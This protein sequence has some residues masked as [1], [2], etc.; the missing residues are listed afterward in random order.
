MTP[1]S[2]QIHEIRVCGRQYQQG[3][4]RLQQAIVT[5]LIIGFGLMLWREY[6]ISLPGPQ[7]YYF[8]AENHEWQQ[9]NNPA[10]N[11]ELKSVYSLSYN[12]IWYVYGEGCW[13]LA[14]YSYDSDAFDYDYSDDLVD[15]GNAFEVVLVQPD[16]T[17]WAAGSS[18]LMYFDGEDWLYSWVIVPPQQPISLAAAYED[19]VVML[20]A[21]EH[22]THAIEGELLPLALPSDF[23]GQP[24]IAGFN[25]TVWLAGEKLWRLDQDT[26][27]AWTKVDPKIGQADTVF[28]VWNVT[29]AG[30]WLSLDSGEV[31]VYDPAGNNFYLSHKLTSQIRGMAGDAAP[32]YIATDTMLYFM[33]DGQWQNIPL[34]ATG[35]VYSLTYVSGFASLTTEGLR[36]SLFLNTAGL[37]IT[38]L[39]SPAPIF[40]LAIILFCWIRGSGDKLTDA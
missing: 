11:R 26:K 1:E 31:G 37:S 9:V 19:S 22:L 25:G 36:S 28:H 15:K 27:D 14:R 30:V 13:C 18:S 33:D 40:L 4:R 39:L 7:A 8:D 5:L 35:S 3:T 20:N 23:S 17:A 2:E 10:S 34:P 24:S 6:Q 21:D 16:E 38:S 32:E 29:E 12:E